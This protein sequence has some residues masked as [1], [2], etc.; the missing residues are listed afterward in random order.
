MNDLP[1]AFLKSLAVNN[2][3][4]YK[5]IRQKTADSELTQYIDIISKP[6]CANVKIKYSNH[7]YINPSTLTQTK[8]NSLYRGNDLIVCGKFDKTAKAMTAVISSISCSKTGKPITINKTVKININEDF[9]DNK[10]TENEL[11]A[12]SNNVDRIWAYLSLQQH[13]TKKLKYNDMIEMDEDE[14]K[15]ENKVPLQLAMKYKFVTPWTSMIV[16]KH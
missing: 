2:N 13:A 12:G 8:F 7:S 3:G 14:Q 16:V 1:H 5:R 6:I 9:D 10:E 4:F 15:Q 11:G